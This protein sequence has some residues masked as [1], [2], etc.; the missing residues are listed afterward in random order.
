MKNR[1]RDR[2][3]SSKEDFV[4]HPAFFD[5]EN[6]LTLFRK[7]NRVTQKIDKDILQ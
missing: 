5:S 6:Y 1:C 4:S 3:P 2:R 7:F